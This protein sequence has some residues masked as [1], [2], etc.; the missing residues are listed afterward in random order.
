MPVLAA[1]GQLTE[2][3]LMRL[4]LQ[5]LCVKTLALWAER[6]KEK[7]WTDD[8]RAVCLR[9]EKVGQLR[10][11]CPEGNGQNVPE[12]AETSEYD[13]PELDVET[14]AKLKSILGMTQVV[15]INCVSWAELKREADENG[16]QEQQIEVSRLLTISVSCNGTPVEAIVDTGAE[17]SI[18][19]PTLAKE[20]KGTHI[21]W[22][23]ADFRMTN[24]EIMRPAAAAIVQ[25]ALENVQVI[26][27]V[28]A[29]MEMGNIK[30]LLGNDTLRRFKVLTVNYQQ[31]GGG[32]TPEVMLGESSR[33]Q[34]VNQPPQET[35]KT[36]CRVGTTR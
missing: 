23:G 12:Q 16:D 20:C 17:S 31:P 22:S 14:I 32:G 8:G 1:A 2:S 7:G 19:S 13:E 30:L 35:R 9:C 33:S 34:E 15:G 21:P 10:K 29:I 11:D 18:I 5:M 3:Q 36:T 4:Q 24:G 27:S 26:E 6:N 28:V 25:L